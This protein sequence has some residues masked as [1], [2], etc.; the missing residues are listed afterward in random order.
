MW[1][2]VD[3]T[4]L[5]TGLDIDRW[6]DVFFHSAGQFGPVDLAVRWLEEASERKVGPQGCSFCTGPNFRSA[7]QIWDVATIHFVFGDL[8][9]SGRFRFSQFISGEW[10]T[11]PVDM[12]YFV[13]GSKNRNDKSKLKLTLERLAWNDATFRSVTT[14]LGHACLWHRRKVKEAIYIKQ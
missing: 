4:D 11:N 8:V 9:D 10:Q 1:S 6:P 14:D 2:I 12:E 13:H 3:T 5:F 7:N